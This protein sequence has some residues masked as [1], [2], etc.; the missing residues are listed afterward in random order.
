MFGLFE[1]KG[2]KRTLASALAVAAFASTIKP[3]WAPY[4]NLLVNMAGGAGVIALAHPGVL[5][6]I[7]KLKS[8]F[9]PR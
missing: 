8:I 4:T 5:K 6:T 9:G 3:D 2:V 1:S 7:E